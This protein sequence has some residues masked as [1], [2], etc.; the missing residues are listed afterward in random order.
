M[1]LRVYLLGPVEIRQGE[2]PIYIPGHRPLA[3][4][5]YLLVTGKPHSRQ[6]LTDLLF[7]DGPDDP[8]AALRWTLSKLRKAIGA[9]FIVADR[10]EIGFNFDSHYWLDV[11][12]FEE[13]GQLDLY[14]GDFLEGLDVRDALGFEDWVFYNR[15][16]LRSVYE[17][18]LAQWLA[19]H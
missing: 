8:R 18:A 16:R 15:E 1:I 5:T 3:L 13:D 9:E 12:V 4:L 17:T 10:Q 6:H 11:T 19:E 14:R 7:Y 2:D